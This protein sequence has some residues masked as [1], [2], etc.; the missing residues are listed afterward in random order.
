MSS[1]GRWVL[2]HT[3]LEAAVHVLL[4]QFE[5]EGLSFRSWFGPFRLFA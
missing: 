1:V 3:E 4:F 5:L 2:T